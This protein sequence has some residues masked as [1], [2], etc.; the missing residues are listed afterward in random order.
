MIYEFKRAF[1]FLKKPIPPNEVFFI[2]LD[3]NMP[4]MDGLETTREI[5]KF[6]TEIPIIALTAVEIEEM[7]DG[8]IRSGM[9]DIIVKPY[10]THQLFHTVYRNLLVPVN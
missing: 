9:N 2:L 3:L 10:D 6:N 8:I 4:G 5:R 7:R 1:S